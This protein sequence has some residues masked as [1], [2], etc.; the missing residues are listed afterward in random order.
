MKYSYSMWTDLFSIL[1]APT[2]RDL[3]EALHRNI[4]NWSR[5][6]SKTKTFSKYPLLGL[7]IRVPCPTSVATACVWSMTLPQFDFTISRKM[8]AG[9][10]VW[11]NN[12][13]LPPCWSILQSVI[14][15]S[16]QI[17]YVLH[18]CCTLHMLG[19]PDNLYNIIGFPM[20]WPPT[21][22]SRLRL[23][24]LSFNM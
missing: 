6:H 1:S 23:M 20:E 4:S 21:Y 2:R 17:Q 22:I 13:H 18:H 14:L 7:L 15:H 8:S 19:N 10:R 16:F 12:Y 11:S 5:W 3:F 9:D 24:L